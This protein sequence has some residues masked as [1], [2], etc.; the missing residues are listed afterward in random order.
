MYASV[1][2]ESLSACKT[3]D[4]NLGPGGLSSTVKSS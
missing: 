2:E 1:V 4:S 3:K